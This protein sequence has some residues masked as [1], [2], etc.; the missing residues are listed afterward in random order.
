MTI[1]ELSF[2][3]SVN[4]SSKATI[5]PLVKLRGR[6]LGNSFGWTYLRPNF[7]LAF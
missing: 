4:G 7:S 3:S 6:I 5:H 2:F 1:Q